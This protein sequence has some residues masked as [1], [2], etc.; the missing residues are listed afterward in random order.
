VTDEE[1]IKEFRHIH[2]RF[3][4]LMGQVE[5]ISKNKFIEALERTAEQAAPLVVL[6]R[7]MMRVEGLLNDLI[8]RREMRREIYALRK[9]RREA[10]VLRKT[11]EGPSVWEMLHAGEA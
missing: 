3:D 10:A 2:D 9:A 7:R 4:Y 5:T 8:D 6:E 1:L 11:A